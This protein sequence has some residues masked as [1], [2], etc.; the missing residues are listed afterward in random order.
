MAHVV[1]VAFRARG[2]SHNATSSAIWRAAEA[3]LEHGVNIVAVTDRGVPGMPVTPTSAAFSRAMG[4]N[5]R[6][7]RSLEDPGASQVT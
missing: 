5:V 6:H 7:W 4:M 2:G 1:R 3:M